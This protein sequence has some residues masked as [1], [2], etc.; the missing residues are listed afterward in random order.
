[1]RISTPERRN[2]RILLGSRTLRRRGT[3]SDGL[4]LPR[5]LL[6]QVIKSKLLKGDL[7]LGP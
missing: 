4:A 1:M 7:R 5:V 6:V 2:L 3:K